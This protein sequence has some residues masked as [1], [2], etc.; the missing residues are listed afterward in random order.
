[1]SLPHNESQTELPIQEVLTSLLNGEE[2]NIELAASEFFSED[3]Y[4]GDDFGEFTFEVS[5]A[6]DK[7]FQASAKEITGVLGE[8]VFSGK[9][10]EAFEWVDKLDIEPIFNDIHVWEKDSK[11]VYLQIVWEDKD[12]PIVIDLGAKSAD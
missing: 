9:L 11:Y 12:C 3:E 8:P 6:Y 4:E 7:F 10:P 1:M 2:D 5:E